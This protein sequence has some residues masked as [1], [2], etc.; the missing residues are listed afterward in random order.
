MEIWSHPPGNRQAKTLMTALKKGQS[1]GEMAILNDEPRAE[2][3]ARIG[4]QVVGLLQAASHAPPATYAL[5][6][7]KPVTIHLW[8]TSRCGTF[9]QICLEALAR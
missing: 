8:Q 2:V 6:G 4:A 1:F 5:R 3:R 7:H 9:Q